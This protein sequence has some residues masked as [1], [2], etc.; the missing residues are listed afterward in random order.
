MNLSLQ[1]RCIIAVAVIFCA[2]FPAAAKAQQNTTTQRIP[3]GNTLSWE[4]LA[5][6]SGLSGLKL[7]TPEEYQV[8][9][10]FE[11]AVRFGSTVVPCSI[12][13]SIQLTPEEWARL[14][15]GSHPMLNPWTTGKVDDKTWKSTVDLIFS[16]EDEADAGLKPSPGGD[17]DELLKGP[18][19]SAP[20]RAGKVDVSRLKMTDKAVVLRRLDLRST[21]LY[22]LSPN[23]DGKSGVLYYFYTNY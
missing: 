11:V 1:H 13:A 23:P 21:R 3:L 10:R 8:D 20:P 14:E 9:V 2:L 6:H 18:F 16:D 4:E 17:L 5:A 19:S 7:K 15:S 12:K 22:M